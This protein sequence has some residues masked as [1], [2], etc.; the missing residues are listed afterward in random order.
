MMTGVP[1]IAAALSL[2][3]GGIA[4]VRPPRQLR[5]TMFA[6]GMAAFTLESLLI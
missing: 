5:Q 3:L 6:A 4:L 1:L 2:I